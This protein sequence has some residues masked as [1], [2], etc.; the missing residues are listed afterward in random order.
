MKTF[1]GDKKL[2]SELIKKLKNHQKLD[3]FIQGDWLTD[4][5]V[6]GNGFK[7][8]FYGCTMQTS[9]NPIEQFSDKYNIDLWY[10]HLTEKL[11]EKLPDGD[12]QKFPLESI[13]ILPVGINF[14]KIKSKFH[15]NLLMDKEHGSI[16]YCGDNKECIDAIKQ[17][18]DLFKVDFDKIDES[19]ARSAAESAAESAARSAA[20]SAAWSA[21][22]SAAESARSAAESAAESAARSAAWSAAWSARSAA[23]SAWS[24]HYIW[25]RNMLFEVI[26]TNI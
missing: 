11:F 7:G 14:N 16:N 4:I 2:K 13:K 10:C 8:C 26:K 20:R 17:C 6:K 24:A 1:D 23:E 25:L 18:A 22:W 3:T 19:A 15:Y 9:E 21:A 5:K 12:Y